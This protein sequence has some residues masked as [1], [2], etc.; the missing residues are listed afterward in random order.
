MREISYQVKHVAINVRFKADFIGH[1]ENHRV[2]YVGYPVY[3]KVSILNSVGR[4]SPEHLNVYST[5]P[6]LNRSI[7]DMSAHRHCRL[8]SFRIFKS[9]LGPKSIFQS[10]KS[11]C[12]FLYTS[13][14]SSV[15][16]LFIWLLRYADLSTNFRL[17][18]S[19]NIDGSM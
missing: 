18:P 5:Q 15:Q 11:I 7:E 2:R 10:F 16:R 14:S 12:S 19:T 6:M 1:F 3:T 8:L 9:S 17:W 4:I 13:K